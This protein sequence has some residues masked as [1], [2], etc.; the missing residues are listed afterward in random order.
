[1]SSFKDPKKSD[2][3][4]DL[5][6]RSLYRQ[7]REPETDDSTSEDERYKL[8]SRSRKVDLPERIPKY[9]DDDDT[10]DIYG[11][12]LPERTRRKADDFLDSVDED[13]YEPYEDDDTEVKGKRFGGFRRKFGRMLSALKQPESSHIPEKDELYFDD[14]SAVDLDSLKAEYRHESVRQKQPPVKKTVVSAESSAISEN[15]DQYISLDTIKNI[16][17]ISDDAE[18][19]QTPEPPAEIKKDD[20]IIADDHE[21]SAANLIYTSK[22]KAKPDIITV[23]PLQ[24]EPEAVQ[25]TPDEAEEDD[26]DNI[27]PK[28]RPV[29]KRKNELPVFDIF[30]EYAK[31]QREKELAEKNSEAQKNVADDVQADEKKEEIPVSDESTVKEDI[32]K[33]IPEEAGTDISETAEQTQ[34]EE[35]AAEPAEEKSDVPVEEP[36]IVQAETINEDNTVNKADDAVEYKKTPPA[37]VIKEK[38]VNTTF[39]R[40]Q[41]R[42]V[43]KEEN[44]EQYK[45]ADVYN[46]Y[47]YE[48]PAVYDTTDNED[49]SAELN[50]QDYSFVQES[51]VAL[52]MNM[53]QTENKSD[54]D[55][56]GMPDVLEFDTKP[57]MMPDMYRGEMSDSHSR[58]SDTADTGEWGE[59]LSDEEL[60]ADETY[61]E[62]EQ[63]I[64][65]LTES[66]IPLI[67]YHVDT[68]EPFI[69]M[70]GKFSKTVRGEYEAVRAYRNKGK[71]PPKK[72][73]SVNNIVPVS[74]PQAATVRPEPE[75]PI[76]PV[77]AV[78]P[79]S[80]PAVENTNVPQKTVT[81]SEIK[82]AAAASANADAPKKTELR[83]P[84]AIKPTPKVITEEDIEKQ[85]VKPAP[86]IKLVNDAEVKNEKTSVNKPK[87]DAKKKRKNQEPPKPASNVVKLENDNKKFKIRDLFG[88][89][90]EYDPDDYPEPEAV[91]PQ[92]DDYTEEKDAEA[93]ENEI[94]TSFQTVLA[95]TLILTGTTVLSVALALISQ[96]TPL[97]SENIKS[98]WLWYAIISF[99][100]FSISV[101][102][103]RMPIVNGL[104][105]LK[106]FKGNPDTAIAVASVAV[107]V[108]SI[109][110]LFIPNVFINGTMYI[111]VPLLLI[112]LL[113][114][115]VGKLMIITR[116]YRNF[117]Y[118]KRPYPKFAG[119]I[120]KDAKT[121][122][123][124]SEELLTTKNII[125]YTKRVKFMKNFLQLSYMPDPSERAA[126]KA[127]PVTTA[128]ALLCGIMYGVINK[129]LA[130]A[131]SS[132]AL[133][134]C[135]GVP[136]ICLLAVNIPLGRLCKSVLKGGAMI[137]SYETV[138]QFCDTTA[139]VVDSSQLYPKGSVTLSGMKAFN[140]GK[141]ND[142]ILA[143][144][145]IMY[146]VNGNMTHVFENIVQC[147]KEALPEVENVLYE[148]EK[149]LVGWVRGQRI[150]I[151]NRKLL[152]S[153]NIR[154]P[155]IEL[156][157]RY[158]NMGNDIT[159]ISVGGE[160]IAMFILSYKTDRSIARELR[161]LEQNG[162]NLIVRTV[163]ANITKEKIAKR[164]GLF[165]RCI[166]IL[167]TH[168]GNT[169]QDM[170]SEPDESARAYLATRGKLSSFAKAVSG[171]IRIRA[172]AT[173]VSLLQYVG[174]VI[175]MIL[176]TLISF[177]SGFEMLGFFE[178]LIFIGFWAITSVIVTVIKK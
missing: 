38:P 40:Y 39:K 160:L 62:N 48:Q 55:D 33:Q 87:A 27:I 121:A 123:E 43:V 110:S 117:S 152:V 122:K 68:E 178:I 18:I 20:V 100:L 138:K 94:T 5:P 58:E 1:M 42:P 49:I 139:I 57:P 158:T 147:R 164:F 86:S 2:N 163:D 17:G 148:D 105:P 96:F 72:K 32:N 8:K 76:V 21:Y 154:V 149:G 159:Y 162:V 37:V 67:T 73:T 70:A 13:E 29:E 83:K 14:E 46:R 142:A 50:G 156:E 77:K 66:D 129:D 146:A 28:K 51:Y 31:E 168:L 155:S 53:P 3:N 7:D 92:L 81:L 41:R 126:S 131:V 135:M 19:I 69:V 153:H 166:S 35:P 74:K 127:A 175:G 111:Y 151:G 172:K 98:G 89:E 56:E 64:T 102:A 23:P 176:I 9:E 61:S 103:Y 34:T 150:L 52:E 54:S 91:E 161:N 10:S 170:T 60:F 145:A 140:Q 118:L 11:E 84:P 26:T 99:M 120:L 24:Q 75:K 171:C 12:I 125:G 16:A 36:V 136:I 177:V 90:E 116:T 45:E 85:Q 101:F 143:G 141:L 15:G 112:A 130:G 4:S 88:T 169:Y 6:I 65:D 115:S 63:D 174:I 93:I 78:K 113:L 108:Q 106:R 128:V 104:L 82:A 107:A 114:N 167:P 71:K 173:I 79:E 137:T 97:F 134:A 22:K 119:K 30:E 157:E 144:A 47:Q 109:T 133:T 59:P 95:R 165:Y 124:M 44:T 132:F 25:E 80:K